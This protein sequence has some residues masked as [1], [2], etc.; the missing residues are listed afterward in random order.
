[1]AYPSS[2]WDGKFMTVAAADVRPTDV[3][4]NPARYVT[5]T[6]D[7]PDGMIDI[8]RPAHPSQP[9]EGC[10]ARPGEPCEW[11]CLGLAALDDATGYGFADVG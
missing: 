6:A 10:D 2:G 3:V 1:M 4:L 5:R 11:D 7:L 8:F 9:C